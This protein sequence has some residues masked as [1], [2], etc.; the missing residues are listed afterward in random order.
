MLNKPL[1]GKCVARKDKL[2]V[3]PF[4][5]KT[6]RASHDVHGW[7]SGN[8]HTVLVVDDRIFVVREFVGDDIAGDG[9]QP[10]GPSIN[11]PGTRLDLVFHE[12]L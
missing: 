12:V 2:A 4:Q 1:I 10:S 6:D 9:W 11:V 3:L 8:L 7:P 5:R